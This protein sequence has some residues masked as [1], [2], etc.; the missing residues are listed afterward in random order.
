[1]QGKLIIF[2]RKDSAVLLGIV[3]VI[4]IFLFIGGARPKMRATIFGDAY[5]GRLEGRD[6]GKL[7]AEKVRKWECR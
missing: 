5:A 6:A 4:K 2:R 1:L 3:P 7:K